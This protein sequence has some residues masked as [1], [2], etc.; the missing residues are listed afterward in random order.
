[1]PKLFRLP[2]G[3]RVSADDYN[4]L[5]MRSGC[6]STAT[7]GQTI[8]VGNTT[9]S[10][11]STTEQNGDDWITPASTT[12]TVPTGCDGVYLIQFIGALPVS[13][14]GSMLITA[15]GRT[16]TVAITAGNLLGQWLGFLA[17][18]NT[19]TV[20]FANGG[21]ATTLS[22]GTLTIDRAGAAVA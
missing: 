2:F 8:A 4:R 20:I 12:H 15:G 7:A 16:S 22:S 21:A 5:L 10:F 17:A 18:G 19:I 13:N 11:G 3:R 6:S 9:L 1:M 14:S